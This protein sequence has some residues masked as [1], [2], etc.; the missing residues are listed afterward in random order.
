MRILLVDDHGPFRDA[1]RM[2]LE[3]E[4]CQVVAEADTGEGAV[5]LWPPPAPTWCWSTS[6]CRAS[7]GS[8]RLHCSP[9][10]RASGDRADLEPHAGRGRRGSR[11][12]LRRLRLRAQGRALPRGARSPG[13]VTQPPLVDP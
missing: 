1:A 13:G 10:G 4:A 2:L 12:P 9:P 7:T 6:T 5:A 3:A 11:R 8:R